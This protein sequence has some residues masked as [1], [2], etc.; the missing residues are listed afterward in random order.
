MNQ[1]LI[2]LIDELRKLGHQVAHTFILDIAHNDMDNTQWDLL[3][4][5][6]KEIN[7]K[8]QEAFSLIANHR[9]TMF[10]DKKKQ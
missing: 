3:Q 2:T 4:E 10:L 5:A 8:S 9:L 7:A 6:L 1:E